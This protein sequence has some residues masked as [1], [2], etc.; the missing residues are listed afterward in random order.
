[1]QFQKLFKE[2]IR[3][4][5]ITGSFRKWRSPQAKMGGRYNLHPVGAIVVTSVSLVTFSTISDSDAQLSGFE[6]RS[7]L[8]RYL[9]AD[10]ND[11]VYRVDFDYLGDKSVK[12]PPRFRL[13][14]SGRA[15][16]RERLDRM[17]ERAR[18]GPWVWRTLGLIR[19]HPGTR[20][21]ILASEIGRETQPFKTNVVKLKQLGLTISL[22]T[23]CPL[24]QRGD[25]LL[26]RP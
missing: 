3:T 19:Q 21:A 6:D 10:E 4:G 23:G 13:S 15:T 1:M 2:S 20:A 17:D 25:D 11:E 18:K 16:M 12:Q 8:A 22:E 24:S 9:E 26:R 14:N 5:S 7:A